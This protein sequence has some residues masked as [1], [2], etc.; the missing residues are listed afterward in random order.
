MR[1]ILFRGKVARGYGRHE[2]RWVKGSLVVKTDV[3][4]VGIY[5]LPIF[6]YEVYHAFPVDPKT[7]G[8]YTGISDNYGE[9]IYEGDRVLI[10]GKVEPI[11]EVKWCAGAFVLVTCEDF[12]VEVFDFREVTSDRLTVID[13]I[14]DRY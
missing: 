9:A 1:E 11:F 14:H 6:E 13:N 8:Q 7:V 12:P 4:V 2:G 3:D 5:A 10:D